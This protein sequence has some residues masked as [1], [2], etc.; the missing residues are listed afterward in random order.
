MN[1]RCDFTDLPTLSCAH[2]TGSSLGDVAGYDKDYQTGLNTDWFTSKETKA[3][4][5]SRR[6]TPQKEV[7]DSLRGQ[8]PN[9]GPWNKT[10]EVYGGDDEHVEFESVNLEQDH[11]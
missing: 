9:T 11:A 1:T 7:A 3:E 5:L 6:D 10:K 2:C 4:A 8:R